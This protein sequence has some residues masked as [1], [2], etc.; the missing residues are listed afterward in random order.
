MEW[1]VA[2]LSIPPIGLYIKRRMCMPV[3][4]L[5]INSRDLFL[6]EFNEEIFN[7]LV[8]KIEFTPNALSF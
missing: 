8:E 3:Y 7:V 1:L 4:K 5:L 2:N 6:E